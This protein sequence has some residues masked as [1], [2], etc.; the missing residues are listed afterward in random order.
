MNPQLRMLRLEVRNDVEACLARIDELAAVPWSPTS[1]DPNVHA[2]V[3]MILHH[4]YG[5]F[6]AALARIARTLGTE[7]TGANWHRALLET[8]AMDVPGVRPAVLSNSLLPGLRDLLSFRHFFRHAYS[9]TLDAGRL[10]T[11]RQRALDVRAG[12]VTDFAR[13]DG[14]L[15][16]LSEG[17]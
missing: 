12:L 3:A 11:L 8:M 7:P 2:R 5:A 17:V 1:V 10:T 9:V 13:V 16:K 6:E 14:W 15:A 4:A